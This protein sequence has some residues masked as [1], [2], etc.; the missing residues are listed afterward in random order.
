MAL[1]LSATKVAMFISCSDLNPTQNYHLL[2]QSVI[3]RPIAWILTANDDGQPSYNLAP[4]SFFTPVC[5]N[6]PTFAVS[7]GK[8]PAGDEKDTFVNLLRDGHC[9]VHIAAVDQMQVLNE[10]SATLAY[11][12]SETERLQLAL[13]AV[14]GQTLPRM[15]QAPVAYFC[16]MTQCV[17]IG[18]GNQHVVFLQA[19]SCWLAD[20]IVQQSS[21]RL[22][23]GAAELNPLARLGGADYARLGEL[24]TLPRPQ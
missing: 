20:D 8:K 5:A 4:F 7:M 24:F 15:A 14:E 21:P 23:I 13:E 11:G 3:P 1:S 17:D 16:H 22:K 9:V 6:P 2:I 12:D 18:P 10:S 19:D